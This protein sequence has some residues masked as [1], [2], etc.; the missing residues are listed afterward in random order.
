ML[1][2]VICILI[3][4]TLMCGLPVAYAFLGGSLAY[5]IATGSA[6]APTKATIIVA[7]IALSI[8]K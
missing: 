7:I 3:F 2:L 8:L 4:V 6:I 1:L 5:L